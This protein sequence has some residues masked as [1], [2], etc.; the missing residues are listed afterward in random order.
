MKKVWYFNMFEQPINDQKDWLWNWQN[1]YEEVGSLK[2]AFEIACKT[3][4]INCN[5]EEKFWRLI[6]AHLYTCYETNKKVD[7]K[8]IIKLAK[9]HFGGISKFGIDSLEKFVRLLCKPKIKEVLHKKEY[10]KF[11]LWLK[12]AIK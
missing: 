11:S 8:I 12:G 5:K 3:K 6:S 9:K 7:K 1:L 10:D 4:E 2:S